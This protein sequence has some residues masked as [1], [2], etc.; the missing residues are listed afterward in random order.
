[1]AKLFCDRRL[2]PEAELAVYRIAQAAVSNAVRH[3]QP[4]GIRLQLE[5]ADEGVTLTAE[6]DGDG[7]VPS[8]MPGDLAAQG[9][10]GLVGMYERATALGGHLSLRSTPGQ[11][12]KVVA[13]IPYGAPIAVDHSAR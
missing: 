9:H 8:E 12:T 11:G 4:S 7:F 5:F 13:F 2:A 1:M 6:D 3:G 10:F